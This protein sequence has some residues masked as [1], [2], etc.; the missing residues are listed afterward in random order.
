MARDIDPALGTLSGEAAGQR[1]G[2][3]A[4][5]SQAFPYT[6]SSQPASD[7]TYY[8]YPMLKQPTWIWSIP[9]YFYVGGVA[10]VGTAFGAAAH[11]MAPQSMRSLVQR[12]RWIGAI[13]GGVSAALLIHDLGRPSRFLYMLRVFRV[14]SPM[15]VGSWILSAF[16][17]CVGGA[18]LL[19]SGPRFSRPA[20]PILGTAGGLLGLGLSGY[21]GVLLSQTAVPIWQ[22]SYRTMPVLFLSS[23]AAAA[24]ALLEFFAWNRRETRAIEVFGSV[25][26]MSELLAV[27]ALERDAY[28]L[29]RIARPLKTGL[30]G[31]LWQSAKALTIAG[32]ILSV[33]PGKSRVKRIASGVIGTAAGLCLRFGIF[34]AGKASA[35]D[36]RASFEQQRR[37]TKRKR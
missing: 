6:P 9:A 2:Q 33:A 8:G 35:R 24:A 5:V 3:V 15:S 7:P 37:M 25:A 34:Y 21:T 27:I 10:G 22:A 14:S 13:G 29:E 30:S 31:F 36:P 17:T 23:G 11:L 1:S 20:V 19:P 26:R 4:L 16:S 28:R 18:C 32:M 12:S